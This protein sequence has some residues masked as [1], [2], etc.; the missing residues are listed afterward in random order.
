MS[1]KIPVKIGWELLIILL[2]PFVFMVYGTID[3][4][5]ILAIVV[6]IFYLLFVGFTLF[7]IRY[8]IEKDN[9]IITNGFFWKTEIKIKEIF[10]IEK[11]WNMLASPAP[12]VFGRVEIYFPGNSIVISPKNFEEFKKEI[13]KINPKITVKN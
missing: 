4:P 7:G 13:L 3:Q 11:T 1:K 9:L 8:T 12:S 5:E 10:K 2:L 6:S